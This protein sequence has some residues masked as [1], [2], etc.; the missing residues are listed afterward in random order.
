MQSWLMRSL[1]I[2]GIFSLVWLAVI[3]HWST[4]NRMPNGTDVAIYFV[5]FPI[6]I[7]IAIWLSLKVWSFATG[8]GAA[9]ENAASSTK[10]ADADLAA[11]E[12]LAV[13]ERTLSIAVLA[14]AIRTAHGSSA[15]ELTAN[16]KASEA[17]LDL[18]PEL[19]NQDGFPVLTGRIAG[20]DEI[21]Q[22]EALSSWCRTIGRA[23]EDW[24]TEQLRTIAIGSEV[25]IELAQQIVKH[26][27]LEPYITALAKNRELP[28]LPMLQLMVLLPAN[29][30]DEK[31]QIAVDWFFHLIQ[32]QGWPSEK[33]SFR[34]V[35]ESSYTRALAIIDQL[36]L[37][38]FHM[39]TPLQTFFSMVI[40]CESHLGEETIQSWEDA[41]K[42]FVG[43]NADAGKTQM[44]GEAA[45]GVLLA[46]ATQAQLMALETNVRLHRIGQYR[47]SKSIDDRGNVADTM[48]QEMVQN[49]LAMSKISADKICLISADTD[50]RSTRI[51]EL[52]GLGTKLFP[53]LDPNT[54]YVKLASHCG[55]MGV[56]SSL[57]ALVLGHFQV[58]SEVA[59]ALCISNIDTHDRTVA[60]LSPWVNAATNAALNSV[61]NT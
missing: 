7:L 2:G 51:V 26:P 25:V 10:L 59:P 52:M 27:E 9:K 40:A 1:F 38:S 39:Q 23:E 33:I 60:L 58:V 61:K 36:M 48:V 21:A 50:Q 41:G 8:T 24:N 55:D 28:A 13:N 37:A 34:P 5:V 4:N 29:W 11:S 14:S 31:R 57:A 46:D 18:D 42:L 44:P 43:K 35:L 22:G 47:R 30:S 20:I 56:V 6:G 32:Q 54:Q 12:N 15:E 49:A 19:T 45:A 16:I 17:R 3:Y 53:D